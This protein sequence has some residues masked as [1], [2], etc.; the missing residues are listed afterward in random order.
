MI[1]KQSY[2]VN[3]R[4]FI[5]MVIYYFCLLYIFYYSDVLVMFSCN[6]IYVKIIKNY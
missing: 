6:F 5:Y 1:F 3:L 2:F 4:K